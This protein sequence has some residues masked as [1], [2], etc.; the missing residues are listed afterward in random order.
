MKK[1]LIVGALI[2][3][4]VLGT[5]AVYADTQET[6]STLPFRGHGHRYAEDRGIGFGGGHRFTEEEREEFLKERENFFKER[7]NLTEEEREEWFKERTEYKRQAIKEAL[8]NG[9]IT[10]EQAKTLEERIQEKEEFHKENGF[11][12][13]SCNGTGFGMELKG[14][15][16]KG[17]GRGMM[18][19]NKS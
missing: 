8:S 14:G 18:R 19:D 11:K 5:F 17:H 15:K 3:T 12:N 6:E 9:N 7:E 13:E 10:E 2:L 16:G 4:M 1:T